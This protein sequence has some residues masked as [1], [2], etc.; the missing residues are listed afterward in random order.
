MSDCI[1]FLHSNN[2]NRVL[3][4]GCEGFDDDGEE[5][6]DRRLQRREKNRVAAQK[7]RKKQMQRADELHEAYE[8]L[9]QKNRWLKKE[10]EV[11]VEEQRCLTEIL[12]AHEPLC[13]IICVSN[14]APGSGMYGSPVCPD[15][16][17][18]THS[19]QKPTT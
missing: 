7:S 8:C 4:Q 15:S 6:S 14:M 19:P 10:V 12:K 13:S 5:D 18:A 9:E 2:P 17:C 3:L 11:L 16:Q 1:V